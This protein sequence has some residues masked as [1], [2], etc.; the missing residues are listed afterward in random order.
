LEILE[1]ERPDLIITDFMMPGMTG[2]EFA[3]A[4]RTRDAHKHTPMI[5]MSGAQAHLGAGRPDLFIDVLAKPFDIVAVVSM[6][7]KVLG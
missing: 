6:V 2:I 1:R 7:K 4:V 3:E 5:L